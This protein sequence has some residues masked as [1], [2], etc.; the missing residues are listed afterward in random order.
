MQVYQAI[1]P[2]PF[3]KAPDKCWFPYGWSC[4]A[5]RKTFLPHLDSAYVRAV[6]V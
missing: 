1:K 5:A 2:F 4:Q 6:N 3:M